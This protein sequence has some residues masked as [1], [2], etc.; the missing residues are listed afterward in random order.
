MAVGY[1][2][3]IH[4]IRV[5]YTTKVHTTFLTAMGKTTEKMGFFGKNA[6]E[7]GVVLQRKLINVYAK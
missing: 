7:L 6:G 5:A 4:F 2:S 1:N 3:Y